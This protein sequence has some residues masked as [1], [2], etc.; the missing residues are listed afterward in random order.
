[1]EK[2]T[3]ASIWKK[4]DIIN[5]PFLPFDKDKKVTSTMINE[6]AKYIKK[7]KN[8][9][10]RE[11]KL[12]QNIK[13]ERRFLFYQADTLIGLDISIID[14]SSL[15]YLDEFFFLL[16][17]YPMVMINSY[18]PEESMKKI[19]LQSYC[20]EHYYILPI[21]GSVPFLDRALSGSYY[22]E[23][24]IKLLSGEIKKISLED[25][26]KTSEEYSINEVK[27]RFP[28]FIIEDDEISFQ[29]QVT[30]LGVVDEQIESLLS[31]LFNNNIEKFNFQQICEKYNIEK[32]KLELYV[33][34]SMLFYKK[35]EEEIIFRLQR[36]NI[37]WG[38]ICNLATQ[39]EKEMI[40]RDAICYD[41]K[42]DE[43]IGTIRQIDEKIYHKLGN[44]FN[45]Y[46]SYSFKIF[47]F[48][49]RLL[50]TKKYS[51]ILVI[52]NGNM[53]GII[54][55]LKGIG[56]QDNMYEVLDYYSVA[57]KYPNADYEKLKKQSVIVITDVINSGRLIKS[58][59]DFLRQFDCKEICVFSFIISQDF[60]INSFMSKENIELSYLTEK[61]L[62]KIDEILDKEY[63]NRYENDRDLNFRL[64]WGD[65]G[66]NIDI[67]EM[68]DP[69]FFHKN[70]EKLYKNYY[71]YNF[72]LKGDIDYNSYIYQKIKR[73]LK[74]RELVLIYKEYSNLKKI[75]RNILNNE[76]PCSN[77][78]LDEVDEIN[79][80]L[81]K[82]TEG[83][84]NKQ[85]LFI[86]PIKLTKNIQKFVDANNIT[87][88]KFLDI[89][90]Y[91]TYFLD[92]D[93]VIYENDI[94]KS[95]I[96]PSKLKRYMSSSD[97]P[98]IEYLK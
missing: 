33:E 69:Y 8:I 78:L 94:N 4:T 82:V 75:I 16:K 18:I 60:N 23:D 39:F 93:K 45:K 5:L 42:I 79:I 30:W 25:F 44:L 34:K 52:D 88:P 47:S 70:N 3:E 92:N 67:Q 17:M 64:L 55:M 73:L 12:E 87:S 28:Q 20:L 21:F 31:D 35:N 56:M 98:R 71:N 74:D 11:A 76:M 14:V 1:M 91:E 50:D 68:K 53:D 24:I 10:F 59:L 27:I 65:V 49:K 38:F 54:S 22:H 29:P 97:N 86:V 83:Y 6:S 26:I 96:F 84:E 89:L 43:S 15:T 66:K 90:G 41:L 46:D 19:A 95:C 37:Y 80:N 58:A 63:S 9:N 61:E 51:N 77:I 85:V 81:A 36:K 62:N 32:S 13:N 48:I 72:D 40:E 2:F 57:V 7:V